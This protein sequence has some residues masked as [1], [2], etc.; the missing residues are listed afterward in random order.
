MYYLLLYDSDQMP[1]RRILI[2]KYVFW[3][4]V[5]GCHYIIAGIYSISDQFISQWHESWKKGS[6]EG[7][8]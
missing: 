5:S 3:M 7:Q 1:E 6:E 4:M 8:G 2:C